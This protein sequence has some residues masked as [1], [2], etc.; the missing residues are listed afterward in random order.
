MCPLASAAPPKY[1][2]RSVGRRLGRPARR[3]THSAHHLPRRC[4]G[5]EHCATERPMGQTRTRESEEI[6]GGAF[7]GAAP[8]HLE[9]GYFKTTW[10]RAESKPKPSGRFAIAGERAAPTVRRT[11]GRKRLSA[12]FAARY[13]MACGPRH[14]DLCCHRCLRGRRS[15]SGRGGSAER[16]A[17]VAGP[18]RA[19]TGGARTLKRRRR[20]GM[21]PSLRQRLFPR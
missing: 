10:R 2:R 18:S 7:R 15:G 8:V 5:P 20:E 21:Q 12:S 1:R 6:R 11:D 14:G 9:P 4:D 13:A 19:P 16:H 3:P 17:L